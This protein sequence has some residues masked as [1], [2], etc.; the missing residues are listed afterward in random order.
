ME[1]QWQ[2]HACF[3][4]SIQKE[5]KEALKVITDPFSP[6]IGLKMPTV[7]A[8]VLLI[9]H[10]HSDHNYSQ[11]VK[12]NPFLIKEP[13]EYEIKDVFFQAI[14]S[15]HDHC[16]GKERGENLIFTIEAQNLRL[17]HLGDFGQKS[18]SEEQLEKIGEVDILF[19]PVGGIYT[20]NGREAKEIV[21]QL[22]PKIVIPMHYFLPKLK[23]KLEKVEDFLKAMGQEKKEPIK[24]L[25][26]E[27]KNLPQQETE[28]VL[29]KALSLQS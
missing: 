13:G 12:G 29:L 22:E 28:I 8:D 20:I 25:K 4:I 1:I 21:A 14:L 11:R 5:K 17:C 26:I 3:K 2:G 18:L 10:D 23:I 16:Q 27:K 19:I 7:Q 6:E 15:F 9:S 24:K